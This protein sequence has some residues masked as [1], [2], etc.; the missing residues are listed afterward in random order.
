V[1]VLPDDLRRLLAARA[2]AADRVL[3]AVGG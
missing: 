2:A 3:E 1:K